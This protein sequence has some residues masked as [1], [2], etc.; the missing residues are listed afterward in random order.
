MG[1][2]VEHSEQTKLQDALAQLHTNI[3]QIVRMHITRP[4]QIT[5]S[6]IDAEPQ[7]FQLN[8]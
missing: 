3:D 5:T 1:G 2:V 6:N 7:T 8:F 4:C